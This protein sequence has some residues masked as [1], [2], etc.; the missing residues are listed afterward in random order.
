MSSLDIGMSSA[1]RA[2]WRDTDTRPLLR[3][4]VEQNPKADDLEV[5]NLF[6]QE[7]KDDK[8]RLFSIVRRMVDLDLIALRRKPRRRR[9]P[10]SPPPLAAAS[11]QQTERMKEKLQARIDR[12][13][14]SALLALVMPNNKP[15]AECTGAECKT[16]GGWFSALA[17]KVP[18]KATVAETLSEKQ[19]Y[20]LWQAHAK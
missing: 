12:E 7:V 14:K 2:T 5:L 8:A 18:A 11:R 19:V 9:S 10:S 15:L 1:K 13:V 6:W 4:I 17:E 16:F 3:Q 20:R